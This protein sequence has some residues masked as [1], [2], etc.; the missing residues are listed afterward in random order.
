MQDRFNATLPALIAQLTSPVGDM[1]LVIQAFGQLAVT[2]D[3]DELWKPLNHQVLMQTREDN[4]RVKITGLRIIQELYNRLG[5]RLVPLLPE[6][7]P[8]IAELMEDS[9]ENVEATCRD[10]IK[11]IEQHLGESLQKFLK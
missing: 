10:T 1:P 7:M 3:D 11:T 4:S 6:T 2:V 5:D 9:D 8:F